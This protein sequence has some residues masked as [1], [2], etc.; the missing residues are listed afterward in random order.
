MTLLTALTAAGGNQIL[1]R[2]LGRRA[3]VVLVPWWEEACKLLAILS[4]PERP[5]LAVHLL[6]GALE[7]G[8]ATLRR[9]R[10]L[11]LISFCIHGLTG[12]VTAYTAGLTGEMGIALLAAGLLHLF[13]NWAVVN[14]V[15]STLGMSDHPVDPGLGGR[16]NEHE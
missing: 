9:Q 4:L 8:H 3:V 12:G 11:G 10:F 2:L 13:L 16:Y 7:L 5:I 1:Y 15:F 14:L 6:F